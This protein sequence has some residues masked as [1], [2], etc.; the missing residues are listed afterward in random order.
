VPQAAFPRSGEG[1]IR[2]SGDDLLSAALL[3]WQGRRKPKGEAMKFLRILK[4]RQAL[5]R[6][7]GEAAAQEERNRLARDLHDSI[8]QQL[9]SINVGT[10]TA[11]ERWERDPEGAKAALADVRRSAREAM[12]EMQAL[13]HQLRP[14]GLGSMKGVVE[15]LREQCEALGFRSGAK[16]AVELGEEI[17][18]D[19]LPPGAPEALFRIAQEALANVARH[20]RARNVRVGLGKGQDAWAVLEVEDDGQGF[21]VEGAASGMGLRNL[22]ERAESLEGVLQIASVPGTGTKVTVWIPLDPLSSTGISPIE[23]AIQSTTKDL[24][25]AACLAVFYLLTTSPDAPKLSGSLLPILLLGGV[26]LNWVREDWKKT[27]RAAPP[28]VSRLRHARNRSQAF[29]LSIASSWAFYLRS[30]IVDGREVWQASW[31]ATAFLCA[32][33]AAGELTRFHLQSRFRSSWPRWKWPSFSSYRTAMFLIALMIFLIFV[34]PGRL[35]VIE[36]RQILWLLSLGALL[37]YLFAREP[38]VERAA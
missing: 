12:V 29:Q 31:S 17:P 23:T 30:S 13:L 20:A 4:S 7:I 27:P 24:I 25:I 38:R 22:R 16:V 3:D 32:V 14:E 35:D 6:Q 11:Q 8:K 2:R 9:F 1:K 36:S 18:D 26:V 21:D 34:T 10:A 28:D 5:F 37:V 19:R 33:L 15:A